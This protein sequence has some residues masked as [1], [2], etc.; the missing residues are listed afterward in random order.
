MDGNS[1]FEP[2]IEAPVDDSPVF[3]CRMCGQC[4]RGEG[5][6]VVSPTDLVRITRCMGLSER[7]FI[8]TYGEYRGGKLQIRTGSDGAC[9]FF[10]DGRGC[11]VHEGKPDVCRAWPF[12]R[13]NIVDPDSLAMAKEYCPGIEPGCT[14][15][16]FA[17]EGRRYL[18]KHG[19]L[20]HNRESEGHAVILDD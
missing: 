13:G 7:E 10:R 6:I 3:T 8:E 16:A 1:G 2:K 11:I 15:A 20:A 12:F 18:V 4:C 19:L 5:G 17:E 9:I 14:H